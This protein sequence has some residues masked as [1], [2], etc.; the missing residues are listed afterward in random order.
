MMKQTQ[1]VQARV[2]IIEGF[3][4][5]RVSCRRTHARARGT[6]T[7]IRR[8]HPSRQARQQQVSQAMLRQ[9]FVRFVALDVPADVSAVLAQLEPV[10][11]RHRLLHTLGVPVPWRVELAIRDR[12]DL[13]AQIGGAAVLSLQ[14]QGSSKR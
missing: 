10:L 4:H 3:I 1:V 12:T 2:V 7:H 8:P 14:Q 9:A 11:M 13:L 6:R 5:P